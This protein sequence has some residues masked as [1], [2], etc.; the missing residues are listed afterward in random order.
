MATCA[1]PTL[2]P[3]QE[4]PAANQT[5]LAVIRC[6]YE[7]ARSGNMNHNVLFHASVAW[8]FILAAGS[9]YML[10]VM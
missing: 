9:A 7:H 8:L 5:P 10:M 6:E 2:D 1:K 3:G 4:S